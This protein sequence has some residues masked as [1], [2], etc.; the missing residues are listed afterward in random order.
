MR[1]LL[2]SRISGGSV[3]RVRIDAVRPARKWLAGPLDLQFHYFCGTEI[4]SSGIGSHVAAAAISRHGRICRPVRSSRNHSKRI[5]SA[6]LN[7]FGG[8]VEHFLVG[9]SYSRSISPPYRAT[10]A[11]RFILRVG[12]IRPFSIVKSWSSTLNFLIDSKL[13]SSRLTSSTASLHRD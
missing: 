11:L 12:V 8:S 2:A 13:A 10:I 4:R 9:Y 6:T 3:K 5:E 7:S 1:P